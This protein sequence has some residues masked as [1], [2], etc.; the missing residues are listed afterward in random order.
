MPDRIHAVTRRLRG[1]WSVVARATGYAPLAA[2]WRRPP[3]TTFIIFGQDRSGSTLLTQLLCCSPEIRCDNEILTQRV[4]WPELYVKARSM[5]HPAKVYGYKL[6]LHELVNRHG[7][8]PGE[9]L[10]AHVARGGKIIYLKR[11]NIVRQAISSLIAMETGLWRSDRRAYEARRKRKFRIDCDA[12]L[13]NVK[14][15]ETTLAQEQAVLEEFPH[16][17]IVYERDLLD[18]GRHQETLNRLFDYLGVARVP[19]SAG[20][21][22][23]VSP[24]RLTDIVENADDVQRTVAQSPYASFPLD[25]LT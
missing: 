4:L 6:R 3:R 15:R 13:R 20:F 23:R 10:R 5:R 19:V 12:L 21:I 24:E 8:D 14:W 16:L 9:F 17:T 7:I 18:A 11:Q 2:F 25:D 1:Y 22:I